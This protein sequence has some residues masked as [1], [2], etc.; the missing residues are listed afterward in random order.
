MHTPRQTSG[1]RILRQLLNFQIVFNA[2]RAIN[3]FRD[4]FSAV[5]LF[6]SFQRCRRL[7][8]TIRSFPLSLYGKDI[9]RQQLGFDCAGRESRIAGI[10]FHGTFFIVANMKF[11][12]NEVTPSTP[13]A[14]FTAA[15]LLAFY[16]AAQG[17]DFLV[18]TK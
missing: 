8:D 6:L 1:G 9:V 12:A 15:S 3:G 17:D 4:A 18:S 7:Y 13:F 16:K 10:A 11:V 5:A 2:L 14:T